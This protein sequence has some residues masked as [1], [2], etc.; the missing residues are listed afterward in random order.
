[1]DKLLMPI[2]ISANTSNEERF[3]FI[4]FQLIGQFTNLLNTEYK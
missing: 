3:P 2:N 1:M 4:S